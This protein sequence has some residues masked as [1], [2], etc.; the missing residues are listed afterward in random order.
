MRITNNFT[1]DEFEQRVVKT[2]ATLPDNI[3]PSSIQTIRFLLA[4]SAINELEDN[5]T[6]LELEEVFIKARGGVKAFNE[7]L[8]THE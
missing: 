3:W 5:I 4:I 7:W 1:I 6:T 2:V 8:S